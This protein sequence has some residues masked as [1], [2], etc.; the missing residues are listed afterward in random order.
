MTVLLDFWDS[1][2]LLTYSSCLANISILS[3]STFVP[4][5]NPH[6]KKCTPGAHQCAA[7]NF[8]QTLLTVSRLVVVTASGGHKGLAS[9][10]GRVKHKTQNAGGAGAEGHRVSDAYA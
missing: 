4:K 10:G 8:A 9:G 3:W 1:R 6:H 2:V 5:K 7:N